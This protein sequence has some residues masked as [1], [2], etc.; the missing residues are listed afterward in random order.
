MNYEKATPRPGDTLT[1]RFRRSGKEVYA[2]V[3]S[4]DE[5]SGQVS[6]R[7]GNKTYKSLSQAALDVGGYPTNGWV[8]WGLKKQPLRHR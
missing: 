6:V 8:F 3:L 5:A 2:T 1:H 4:V 7:V